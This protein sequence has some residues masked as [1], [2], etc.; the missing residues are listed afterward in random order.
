MVAGKGQE[1]KKKAGQVAKKV[2]SKTLSARTDLIKKI[3]AQAKEKI[4]QKETLIKKLKDALTQ[5]EKKLTETKRNLLQKAK[6]ELAA[7]KEKAEKR[8]KE[9]KQEVEDKRKAL[10]EL[11]KKTQEELKELKEEAASKTKVLANKVTEFESYKKN[12]EEKILELEVK[13]KEYMAKIK[14]AEKERT[15]LITSQ[16]KPITLLGEELKVGDRAPDF[17]V[18]DNSMQ[19]V[20]LAAF[21]G[22]I[23]IITSV[24]SLDTPVCSMETKR[25]NEEAGKL[26]EKV[27]ILT[28][29]M[30]LPFAQARWCAASGVEKVKTFSDYRER[31]FGLAYGVLIKELMLLAR[32]VFIVDD[33]DVIR[34]VELVPEI[35]QEPD[36]ARVLG[37]V[38][39]LL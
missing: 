16:G 21:A 22:K 12:A 13:I 14:P 10:Q 25:F 3:E 23:K 38:Q 35:T 30:D 5:K 11:Q 26:P 19:P 24:P 2:I 6:E 37:A 9:L 7:L 18:L 34:Y 1:I 29:S 4:L 8:A 27:I 17:K 32:G 33:Q 20:S 31:S 15:G 36:Y 39:A 28:I